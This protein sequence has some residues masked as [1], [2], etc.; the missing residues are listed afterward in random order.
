MFALLETLIC[1]LFSQYLSQY[2]GRPACLLDGCIVLRASFESFFR[3]K[4]RIH[5]ANKISTYALVYPPPSH[6]RYLAVVA[7]FD[8]TQKRRQNSVCL[9]FRMRYSIAR[10]FEFY[11]RSLVRRVSNVGPPQAP[12]LPLPL[13]SP[14][15]FALRNSV[16]S[17]LPRHFR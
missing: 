8:S 10:S 6:L 12:T 9:Y 11:W 17:A 7:R 14:I 13:E 5:V 2:V 16:L 4:L 3:R 15:I 1:L